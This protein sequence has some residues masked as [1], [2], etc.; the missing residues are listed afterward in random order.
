MSIPEFNRHGLL[1]PGVHE[2]SLFEIV[3]RLGRGTH[4]KQ[5]VRS[6]SE[7][8][9]EELRPKFSEPVCVGGSFVTDKESPNDID[10]TLDLRDADEETQGRGFLFMVQN[11]QL[12][13]ERY[14]VHFWVSIPGLSDF[15]AFFQY[16]GPKVAHKGLGDKQMKGILRVS[17]D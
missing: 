1:P 10:V 17:D 5:L 6:L 16:A 8:L 4:R 2:C 7:F 11:Q 15:T 9:S 3:E 12:I 14:R 13:L